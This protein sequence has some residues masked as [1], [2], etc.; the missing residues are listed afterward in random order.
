MVALFAREQVEAASRQDGEATTVPKETMARLETDLMAANLQVSQLERQHDEDLAA[1]QSLRK[2]IAEVDEV[3][4]KEM[5]DA[6]LREQE[7][8][9]EQHSVELRVARKQHQHAL[10]LVIAQH[11]AETDALR[12]S[13]EQDTTA[14]ELRSELEA[15]MIADHLT[16]ATSC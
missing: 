10:E 14:E 4:C 11:K 5:E 6:H 3:R 12:E 7:A 8:A 1:M 15:R 16:C 2:S 13:R 9:R